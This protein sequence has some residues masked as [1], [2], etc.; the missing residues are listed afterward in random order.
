LPSEDGLDDGSLQTA[1]QQTAE[2]AVALGSLSSVALCRTGLLCLRQHQ[3]LL[4]SSELLRL[5]DEEEARS[6]VSSASFGV[7]DAPPPPSE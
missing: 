7:G 1:H 2:R 6:C 4:Q 5:L 3:L